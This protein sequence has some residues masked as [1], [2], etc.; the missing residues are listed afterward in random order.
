M[1][2]KQ[3]KKVGSWLGA[4][5]T[6]QFWVFFGSG[7][8]VSVA[9]IDPGNWATGLVAGSSF[10]FALLWVVWLA[11]GMA[12]LFQYLSGKIGVAGYSVAELVKLRW[13]N[14]NLILLYWFLSE[15]AILA[16]DLAEF[17]GIVVALNLLFGIPLIIG[18]FISM[19]DVLLLL[20]LA[21]K[22][23]R[24]LEYAFVLFVST[25]GLAYVY[26]LLIVKPTVFPILYGSLVPILNQ[27]M[28][29]IA[30][31]IIGATIMPHALF[32]HSW[33]TKNKT[34][35]HGK[36]M[37][38]WQ[39]LRYHKADTIFSLV[40]AGLINAA[41]V[42][43]AATVFYGVTGIANVTIQ[44]A[45]Q[46][47]APLFGVAAS[48]VFGLGLLVAG[49]AA[50]ITGTIAGQSIMDALTGFRISPTTRRLITRGINLV[51]IL[52]AISLKIN[53][54]DILVYSQIA[55]SFLIP[56]PLIPLVYYSSKKEIMGD[57]TNAKITTIVAAVFTGLILVFN[58][59]LIFVSF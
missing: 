51:P 42:I 32:V 4:F 41:I 9:Y 10:D 38:R 21:R 48:V 58:I 50:S 27:N 46:T 2:E 59:Y 14:K 13:R 53:P 22:S 26:E 54:F 28:V 43:L 45:Y 44:E 17:L 47:L 23:F 3:T 1:E 34:K 6:K 18:A 20:F 33:L 52:I 30:V 29:F 12:M 31:G 49:I 56:L 24:K 5:A 19:L 35:K 57:L 37:S 15:I 7:L 11:S 8:I 16:T 36:T 39:M 40:I 55:L 25:I